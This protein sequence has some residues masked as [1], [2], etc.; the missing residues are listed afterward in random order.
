MSDVALCLPV[1]DLERML[2]SA[3]RHGH[4]VVATATSA[5]ELVPR[6]ADDVPHLVIAEASP[7]RLTAELVDACDMQG[8]A[9][10]AVTG[11]GGST[12]HGARLGVADVVEAG[13]DWALLGTPE[14]GV[15]DETLHPADE[16]PAEWTVDAALEQTRRRPIGSRPAA[17]PGGRIEVP[18]G[19]RDRGRPPEQSESAAPG[20]RVVVVW[21]PAGAPGRTSIAIALAAEL[22]A[23]GASV[24]LADAD[25]HAASVA[26]ALGLLDEAPGFAA[27]C[28]LAATGEVPGGE[29]DRLAVTVPGVPGLRVLTGIPLP[30]RWPELGAERVGRV[31]D[32]SRAAADVV[33]V[34]VAASLER[35]EELVS[36]LAGPRRNAAALAALEAADVVLA[37]GA[38]DPIG[39]A[40]LLRGHAD[41]AQHV[42][43]ERVRVVVG[44]V[45]ASA[46]G[47]DAAG[48]VR[49]TLRRFGGVQDVALVPWD[50]A[51]FDAA[52]LT[53]RPLPVAA[54][55]SSARAA[56]RRLA[57]SLL[58]VAA[59]PE[60]RRRLFAAAGS[61]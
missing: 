4:R 45:R 10:V 29:L 27:A 32:A 46:V 3:R 37:V 50:P 56:V 7:S 18:D 30:S 6:L 58:P 31:L 59:R 49:A 25:T 54:P 23:A 8:V 47:T 34:D 60:R 2:T 38:A 26:P 55:R 20:G 57:E 40:R 24:I 12:A 33:V 61:H 21:G 5:A 28:R 48:Q 39:L 53:A 13:A 15:V 9:L 52:L 42:D 44:K 19:I 51:A 17:A 43:P 36:D 41:L 16:P 1:F 35:D 22:T 14:T 11:T